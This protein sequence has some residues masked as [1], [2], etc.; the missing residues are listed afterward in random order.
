ML[1]A[2]VAKRDLSGQ[3]LQEKKLELTQRLEALPGGAKFNFNIK[4]PTLR[5]E[6]WEVAVASQAASWIDAD[7]LRRL[8]FA[9]AQQR[10]ATPFM[11]NSLMVF[12]SP[13]TRHT[14]AE[15]R[16]DKLSSSDQY[17]LM[18]QLCDSLEF[19]QDSIDS[20]ETAITGKSRGT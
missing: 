18:A 20:V 19:V 5:R 12:T 4:T 14:L 10:D 3:E 7:K 8:S 2:I 13:A 11:N 15:M 6:A 16:L 9:Y 17:Y 1:E